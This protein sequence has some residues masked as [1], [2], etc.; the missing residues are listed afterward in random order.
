VPS[1]RRP[2]VS[3]FLLRPAAARIFSILSAATT[4]IGVASPI[5]RVALRLRDHLADRSR[6]SPGRLYATAPASSRLAGG[7]GSDTLADVNGGV[8]TLLL[9]RILVGSFT[10]RLIFHWSKRHRVV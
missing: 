5:L 6:S 3:R 1:R 2:T 7:T 9:I 10:G 8:A 4:S